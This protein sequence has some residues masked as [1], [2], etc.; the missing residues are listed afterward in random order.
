MAH[1]TLTTYGVVGAVPLFGLATNRLNSMLTSY[2]QLRQAKPLQMRRMTLRRL[3]AQNLQPL[4]R[5]G[6]VDYSS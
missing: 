3:S 1:D 5:P 4:E 6:Q 2:T